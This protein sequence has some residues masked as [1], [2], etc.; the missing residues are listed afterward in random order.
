MHQSTA[1]TKSAQITLT[2]D[3]EIFGADL[4]ENRALSR[5]VRAC[6]NACEGF[7]TA[8]LEQGLLTHMRRLIE[9]LAPLAAQVNA[10]DER[11]A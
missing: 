5:R 3:G 1:P 9:H 7:T 2:A 8:E 4:P 6:I 11:A 10:G